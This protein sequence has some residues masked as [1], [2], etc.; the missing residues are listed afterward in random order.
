MFSKYLSRQDPENNY[1]CLPKSTLSSSVSFTMNF[2]LKLNF[3]INKALFLPIVV[4]IKKN[5]SK[6][7]QIV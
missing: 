1:L 4:T 7:R 3:C 6:T 5:S 2:A